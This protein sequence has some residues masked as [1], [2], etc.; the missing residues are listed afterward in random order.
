VTIAL[1]AVGAAALALLIS[2]LCDLRRFEIPDTLSIVILLSAGA[3][4]LVTPGFDWLW[5]LAGLGLMF[6]VGLGLFAAGWMGGGD[7][8]LLVATAL[9]TGLQGLPP[10]LLGVSLAGGALAIILLAS[11]AALKAS[12]VAMENM[13]G[14]LRPGAPMPYAIAITGGAFWWAAR[15]WPLA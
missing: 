3:F 2:C 12:G 10:F 14:P 11:R 5:H 8:K 13:P 4:G 9:W 6:A 7:I 1:F 15:S